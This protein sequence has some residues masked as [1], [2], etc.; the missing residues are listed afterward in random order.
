MLKIS[1]VIEVTQ[2]KLTSASL[3]LHLQYKKVNV[4]LFN[5]TF[6]T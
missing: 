1:Q 2:R 6:S 4:D 3:K 5:S